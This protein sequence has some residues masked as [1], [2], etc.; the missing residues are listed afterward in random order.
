MEIYENFCGSSLTSPEGQLAV[1]SPHKVDKA[2]D[3]YVQIHFRIKVNS[4]GKMN[5]SPKWQTTFGSGK[6]LTQTGKKS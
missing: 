4:A 6:V 5:F 2:E 1:L 3:N